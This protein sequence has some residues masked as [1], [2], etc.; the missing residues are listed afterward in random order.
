MTSILKYTS[1]FK[2]NIKLAFPVILGLLGHTLVQLVDNI[3]V[4][5]LG[6]TELAAV[7]LGN[8]F[9]FIGMS[10]GI[11]FSTAITPLVAASDGANNKNRLNKI[12]SHGLFLCSIL[13]VLM[14]IMIY[15]SRSLM[16]LMNQPIEVVRLAFPY[17]LWISISLIPLVIFQGF[18]QFSDG[19]SKTRPAM[20]ATLFSNLINIIVN[21]FLIFGIW[22]FPKLG[23]EGAA[24]GTLISRITMVLFIVIYFRLNNSFRSYFIEITKFKLKIN[25]LKKIL[26]LGFPSALQMLFE[27]GFFA[28]AIWLSGL[29]GSKIQAANQIAL[30]LSTITYM[31]AMGLSVTAMIRVGN[32]YGKFDFYELKRIAYSIFLLIFIL[33][34]IFCLFFLIFHNSLPWIYLDADNEINY[35]DSLEVVSL[36]SNLLIISAIFQ[37]SDGLQ[38]VILGS[39]RGLQDVNKPTTII[40][41][42]YCLIGFPISYYLG[43]ISNLGARGIWIGLLTGLTC[44]ALLNFL[45]FN[46]KIKKLLIL[47]KYKK[48]LK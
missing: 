34:I 46:Y 15:S 6:A 41:I 16:F 21:Y 27:V 11:G 44:S 13:G 9:F 30:N 28:A 19:L 20:Y 2:Y 24:I 42:S 18:K 22:I 48:D 40:F 3:M 31:V 8:S 7:S 32:Q 36:A 25:L 37:I 33:D 23:V 39:L 45:R 10:I 38:A 4:G 1:E 12:L 35:K 47:K 26:E 14:F 5:Q 17:L 43:I 29:L